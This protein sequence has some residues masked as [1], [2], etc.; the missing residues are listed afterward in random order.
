[1]PFSH[2]PDFLQRLS[3]GRQGEASGLRKKNSSKTDTDIQRNPEKLI[4]APWGKRNGE[5]SRN[6]KT[7]KRREE[8]KQ[9]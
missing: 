9:R 5:N 7:M 4:R 3:A 8:V 6:P 1:M 2:N